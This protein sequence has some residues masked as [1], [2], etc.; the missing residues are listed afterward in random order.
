MQKEKEETTKKPETSQAETS[1]SHETQD[2]EVDKLQLPSINASLNGNEFSANSPTSDEDW[3]LAALRL[4]QNFDSII[5]AQQVLTAVK[6][7]KPNNQEWFRIHPSEDWRLQTTV[8]RLKEVNEDYLVLPNLRQAV[9]DE[10]QPV[11]LFTAINRHG[12]VFIWP[13]RLPKGDGRTDPF[14]ESDMVAAK[15]AQRKWTR[16]QW[17]PENRAHR[18]LVANGLTEE[19]VWPE[20]AFQE[21]IKKAFKDK[22]IRDLD[23]PVLK[24]LRGD[25]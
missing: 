20:I 6:V 15:E 17:V 24:N 10:I 22:F 8:L 13:V 25:R 5:G 12:E 2:L 21:L 14:M 19:P 9:W 11:M 3:D 18:V 4:D 7:R 23:H 1:P 16:R